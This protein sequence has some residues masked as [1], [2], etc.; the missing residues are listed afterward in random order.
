MHTY[1][2][3]HTHVHTNARLAKKK[4]LLLP[5]L[6]KRSEASLALGTKEIST[7]ASPRTKK[8]SGGAG[9]RRNEKKYIIK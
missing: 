4:K 5:T 2:N 7:M 6:L 3:V 1:L 8:N 9:K